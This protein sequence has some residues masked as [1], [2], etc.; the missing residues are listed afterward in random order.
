M[1]TRSWTAAVPSQ[2]VDGSKPPTTGSDH[3]TAHSRRS[4]A[5]E[6]VRRVT[7]DPDLVRCVGLA[8]PFPYPIQTDWDEAITLVVIGPIGADFDI[9]EPVE[10]KSADLAE[11]VRVD[12]AGHQGLAH[13]RDGIQLGQE[14]SGAGMDSAL[15]GHAV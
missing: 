14:V 11:G 2:C 12:V 4:G 3:Q 13:A 6:V 8:P 15:D 1:A 7:D 9:E 10:A 5:A